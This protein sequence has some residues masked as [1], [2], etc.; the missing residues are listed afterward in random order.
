MPDRDRRQRY[1]HGELRFHPMTEIGAGGANGKIVMGGEKRPFLRRGWRRAAGAGDDGSVAGAQLL[2]DLVPQPSERG[3]DAARRAFGAVGDDRR[4]PRQRLGAAL[5]GV[6]AR[7]DHQE[8]AERAERE[9]A[10][11]AALPDRR[12]AVPSG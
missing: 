6:L 3:G 9:A 8:G 11:V 10:I 4:E 5:L 2:L 1:I 7:L 12:I